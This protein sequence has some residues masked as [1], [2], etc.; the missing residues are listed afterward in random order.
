MPLAVEASRSRLMIL[1]SLYVMIKRRS[2]GSAPFFLGKTSARML[3]TPTI[4]E[5]R[6]TLAPVTNLSVQLQ[7]PDQLATQPRKTKRPKL[8]CRGRSRRYT[9]K[10]SQSVRMKKT[11]TRKR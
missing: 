6:L 7:A 11:R 10:K 2:L 5:A 8:D 9:T 1:F 3:R 4:K